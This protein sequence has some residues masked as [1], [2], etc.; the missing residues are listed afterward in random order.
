M[1]DQICMLLGD[2]RV[3]YTIFYM[4]NIYLK[5]MGENM[6]RGHLILYFVQ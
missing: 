4:M 6:P 5:E 3:F 1:E 2:E